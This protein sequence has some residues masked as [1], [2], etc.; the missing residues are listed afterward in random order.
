MQQVP[1]TGRLHP[2]TVLVLAAAVVAITTAAGRWWLHTAVLTGCLLLAAR[3][4][5]AGMLVRL[6]AV[7]LVPAWGSQLLIHGLVDTGGGH[8]LA[9]AGPLRITTE[10]LLTA[11]QLGLRT[12]VLVVAGLL[13]SMLIDRHDLVA[14]VDLSSA[15]PQAGYLLAATLSLLPRLAQRQR[16]IGQAQAL[17]GIPL[18][19]GPRGW[20]R[21]VRLRS[22]P[23]VLSSVQDAADRS[24]HLA[25]RGFPAKGAHTRLREVPDSPVQRWVR[26]VALGAMVLGPVALLAPTWVGQG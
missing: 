2:F 24:A 21:S 19:A 26:R 16:A 7:I 9:A 13:C 1:R 3:A 25:A 10:G 8:V 14:A 15:P 11:G 12:G 17:R 4:K 22:V 23:L 18:A 6:G 5:R 20:W